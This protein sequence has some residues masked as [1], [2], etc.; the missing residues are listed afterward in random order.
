SGLTRLTLED[1]AG[2]Q[3]STDVSAGQ[4]VLTPAAEGDATVSEVALVERCELAEDEAH[5]RVELQ[6]ALANCFDRA[7]VTIQANLAQATHGETR[8]EVLGSG[9]AG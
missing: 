5:M 2:F 9:E 1:K 6:R 8:R 4:V 7:T 3:G